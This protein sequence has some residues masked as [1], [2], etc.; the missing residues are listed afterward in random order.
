M[1]GSN[2]HF[3]QAQYLDAKVVFSLHFNNVSSFA[4]IEMECCPKHIVLML[5]RE[6]GD[7]AKRRRHQYSGIV[8]CRF[9]AAV[10]K[11]AVA[12]S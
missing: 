11:I 6:F 9:E 4:T 2:P 1:L 10:E 12:V 7:S 5:W 8:K 3:E